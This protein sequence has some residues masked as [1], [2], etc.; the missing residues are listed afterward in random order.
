MNHEFDPDTGLLKDNTKI[1][2]AQHGKHKKKAGNFI[3]DDQVF[4]VPE[5]IPTCDENIYKITQNCPNIALTKNNNTKYENFTDK[6]E[7]AQGVYIKTFDN[8][9]IVII[10]RN[11]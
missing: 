8:I 11:L 9:L 4:L 3:I 5:E 6:K 10:Q 7:I 2:D 1:F